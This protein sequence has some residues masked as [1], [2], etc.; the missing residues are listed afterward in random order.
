VAIIHHTG[1][2]EQQDFPRTEQYALQ[3]DHAIRTKGDFS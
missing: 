2:G 1:R 3:P